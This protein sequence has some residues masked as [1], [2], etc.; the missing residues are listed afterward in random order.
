MPGVE[1]VHDL[2][3]W[4]L[5]AGNNAMSCHIKSSTPMIS[6]KKATRMINTKYKILR[7][8]IQ[9]EHTNT[10]YECQGDHNR[11]LESEN[12]SDEIEVNK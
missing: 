3:V 10:R 1:E 6:L 2:H 5:S 12:D 4:A 8:T 9:V 11:G 7:T